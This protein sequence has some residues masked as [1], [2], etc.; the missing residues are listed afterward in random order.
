MGSLAGGL[1]LGLQSR[2]CAGGG[3]HLPV[4]PLRFAAAS[5]VSWTCC[6][7]IRGQVLQARD[8]APSDCTLLYTAHLPKVHVCLNLGSWLGVGATVGIYRL[9]FL[10]PGS[11]A[12]LSV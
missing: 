1:G 11:P 7:F 5:S 2:T 4:S 3:I 10:P 8:I 9:S 12:A 6:D